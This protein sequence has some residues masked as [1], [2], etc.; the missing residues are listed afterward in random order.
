MLLECRNRS[1]GSGTI[2]RGSRRRL[3]VASGAV[4]QEIRQLRNAGKKQSKNK[5]KEGL[6]LRA[7]LPLSGLGP[8]PNSRTRRERGC[9]LPGEF[10]DYRAR[11]SYFDDCHCGQQSTEFFV[12]IN[13][14][15]MQGRVSLAFR[16]RF[17]P[18]TKRPRSLF[19]LFLDQACAHSHQSVFGLNLK[20]DEVIT[21]AQLF[22]GAAVKK[23][24]VHAA[25]RFLLRK[26][27]RRRPKFECGRMDAD[28]CSVFPD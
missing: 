8:A 15:A 27:W 14:K 9:L 11:R 19:S 22:A 26:F 25:D 13:R 3:N 10:S 1:N 23:F 28:R 17:V 5:N 7:A 4:S 24:V 16:K 20:L 12:S 21:G 18:D 6:L 2:G